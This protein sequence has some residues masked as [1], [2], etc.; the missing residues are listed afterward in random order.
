MYITGMEMIT[1]TPFK[2]AVI[3]GV[4]FVANMSYALSEVSDESQVKT[5]VKER[6][7]QVQACRSAPVT[8]SP[9]EY[10]ILEIS[11]SKGGDVTIR[12][13]VD[14]KIALGTKTCIMSE[15]ESWSFPVELANEVTIEYPI[16]FPELPMTH[17]PD[18]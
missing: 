18:R 17:A 9:E 11:V 14:A 12:E 8:P 6:H 13:V 5:A 15:V 10:L 3:L 4:V 16:W 7:S 1:G 2:T